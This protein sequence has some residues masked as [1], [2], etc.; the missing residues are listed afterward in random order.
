MS[1]TIIKGQNKSVTFDDTIYFDSISIPLNA[2][3]KRKH[4]DQPQRQSDPRI[5]FKY[6]RS[7]DM[8]APFIGGFTCD[9]SPNIG[10]SSINVTRRG[11]DSY[12]TFTWKDTIEHSN[13][14]GRLLV[15]F[16]GGLDSLNDRLLRTWEKITWST[17]DNRERTLMA[18]LADPIKWESRLPSFND[19]LVNRS[20]FC[21]AI[22]FFQMLLNCSP[23][24]DNLSD[25]SHESTPGS[26]INNILTNYNMY[27]NSAHRIDKA[28]ALQASFDALT[29]D[30]D[31]KSDFGLGQH[32]V[33]DMT[34]YFIKHVKLNN[35]PLFALSFAY[36]FM[37]HENC[38][39]ESCTS[40][41]YS[42]CNTSD[43]L[44]YAPGTFNPNLVK[45]DRAVTI[46]ELLNNL[47]DAR[48]VKDRKCVHCDETGAV[49]RSTSVVYPRVLLINFGR[50]VYQDNKK[51]RITN[52]V[53]IPQFT[54]LPHG[55]T[56]TTGVLRAIW[57]HFNNRGRYYNSDA[58]DPSSY[59]SLDGGHY[60]C[61]LLLEGSNDCVIADD[62][63]VYPVD[64]DTFMSE[65]GR[66]TMGCVYVT[67]C[68][69]STA[70]KRTISA[71]ES[72]T[73]CKK[74]QAYQLASLLLVPVFIF[75]KQLAT[76]R[77]V[78]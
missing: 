50:L 19:G 77:I 52:V 9:Q 49:H 16:I 69:K 2:G 53:N 8:A 20:N 61:L 71:I 78:F 46:N 60:V 11:K 15:S 14:P 32:S 12:V 4:S 73:D 56:A 70:V 5:Q 65:H 62:D 13:V 21:Y 44:H 36:K 68:E 72:D 48:L 10:N 35:P 75:L 51:T 1:P 18:F 28:N 66:K 64:F 74:E 37:I 7:S 24:A 39:Q 45:N 41:I 31:F 23:W 22:C 27:V 67:T 47:F 63:R 59:Q 76:R 30:D 6:A 42:S 40:K 43:E 17:D 54:K 3:G 33:E 25:N 26:M 38:L 34:T 58:K 29:K 55:V 57:F